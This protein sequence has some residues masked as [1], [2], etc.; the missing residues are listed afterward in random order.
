MGTN[1]FLCNS[2]MESLEN[3]DCHPEL[4]ISG[5]ASHVRSGPAGIEGVLHLVRTMADLLE[6]HSPIKSS[7]HSTSH[8][9][10]RLVE[11]WS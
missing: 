8:D 3:V 7:M 9:N 1:L 6:D 11:D 5:G 10:F 2:S 4:H